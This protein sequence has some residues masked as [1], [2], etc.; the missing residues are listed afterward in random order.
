MLVDRAVNLLLIY[1]WIGG[2][3]INYRFNLNGMI[4]N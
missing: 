3:E 1:S 2:H 4:N